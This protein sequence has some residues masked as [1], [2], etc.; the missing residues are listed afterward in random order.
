MHP[1]QSLTAYAS[2]LPGCYAQLLLRL[3]FP[4]VLSSSNNT[5]RDSYKKEQVLCSLSLDQS[6]S[7]QGLLSGLCTSAVNDYH[8]H[9]SPCSK[10]FHV[11]YIFS[12][13]GQSAEAA[14]ALQ[15][16]TANSL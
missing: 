7:V 8:L 12:T 9:D 4:A 1:Q 10:A 11:L 16:V 15:T 6:G 5:F 13:D 3:S 2:C 14:E